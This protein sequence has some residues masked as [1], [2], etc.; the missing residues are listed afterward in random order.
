MTGS[1]E[2]GR[3]ALPD[4]DDM[5]DVLDPDNWHYEEEVSQVPEAYLT[6]GM[7]DTFTGKLAQW[8]SILDNPSRLPFQDYD[9]AHMFA[10]HL[11]HAGTAALEVSGNPSLQEISAHVTRMLGDTDLRLNLTRDLR[12]SVIFDYREILSTFT[13]TDLPYIHPRRDRKN[14]LYIPTSG[15]NL[16][17]TKPVAHLAHL[18]R[19]FSGL[20][21]SGSD[22]LSGR[23]ADMAASA[24][25]N[26]A[27]AEKG[28]SE[29]SGQLNLALRLKSW[30]HPDGLIPDNDPLYREFSGA[31]DT[32]PVSQEPSEEQEGCLSN[33][34]D[35]SVLPDRQGNTNQQRFLITG[36]EAG[37]ELLVTESFNYLI[38]LVPFDELSF[39]VLQRVAVDSLPQALFRKSELDALRRSATVSVFEKGH[40]NAYK[41]PLDGESLDTVSRLLGYAYGKLSQVMFEMKVPGSVGRIRVI[42]YFDAGGTKVSSV[43]IGLPAEYPGLISQELLEVALRYAEVK[44][45]T[46]KLPEYASGLTRKIREILGQ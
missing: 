16:I 38:F 23:R 6:R 9:S 1:V 7:I 11:V 21:D 25:I 10:W 17:R 44:P 18:T 32:D 3:S 12:K 19:A 24:V 27:I 31:V 40:V 39:P 20:Q 26:Q 2:S 46:Y 41:Y 33:T 15:I 5:K 37:M 42:Y 30:M 36:D 28:W 43:G 34:F 13:R 45:R 35:I 14:I 22:H 29:V 4:W 8:Q